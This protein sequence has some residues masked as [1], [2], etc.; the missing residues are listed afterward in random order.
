MGNILPNIGLELIC[1]DVNAL[2]QNDGNRNRQTYQSHKAK[3]NTFNPSKMSTSYCDTI[4]E[5]VVLED[6]CQMTDTEYDK[7]PLCMTRADKLEMMKTFSRKEQTK[8][9]FESERA[10]SN[11]IQTK[12]KPDSMS[13]M[14]QLKN[15]TSKVSNRYGG[16]R[17]RNYQSKTSIRSRQS[18]ISVHRSASRISN[19][20]TA[21]SGS[22]DNK[23]TFNIGYKVARDTEAK[24][25]GAIDPCCCFSCIQVD[26]HRFSAVKNEDYYD[27]MADLR[28]KLRKDLQGLRGKKPG[29][30]RNTGKKFFASIT[31]KPK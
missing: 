6:M 13:K 11:F 10:F 12:I 7:D 14:L 22:I 21:V 18:Q 31:R 28:A 24:K 15:T 17:P 27:E 5:D 1:E 4:V 23:D 16:G 8:A 30:K 2:D 29:G 25:N 19:T 9:Y 26:Q 3:L 20:D